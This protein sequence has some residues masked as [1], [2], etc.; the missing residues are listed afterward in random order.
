M[1]FDHMPLGLIY[2]YLFALGACIGSFLGVVID[3]LPLGESVVRPRSRCGQCRKTLLWYDNLPIL[4][5]L[6]LRGRCRFCRTPYGARSLALELLMGLM[7]VALFARFGATV[8][9]GFWLVAAS[10]LVAITFLDIDYF[11]VPDAITYPL[12]V[13]ALAGALVPVGPALRGALWGLLPAAL[14]WLVA[15]GFERIA[16]KEGLG[17]GDIKLLAA[18]GLMLGLPGG[19]LALFLGSVQGAVLGSIILATGGHKQRS[20]PLPDAAGAETGQAVAAAEPAGAE[21]A[22]VPDPKAV[23]FGP[24][25]VLGALQVLFFPE[26]FA[27]LFHKLL[28]SAG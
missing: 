13:W 14:L 11:W 12:M 20:Q 16:G 25:L 18:L 15:L 28:E 7:F 2:G 21:E 5:H 9:C 23:P 26:V 6:A 27:G 17:F 1:T 10:A 8:A 4:S 24:F 19:L 22:W 3:R